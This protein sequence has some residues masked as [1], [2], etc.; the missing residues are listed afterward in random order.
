MKWPPVLLMIWLAAPVNAWAAALHGDTL[1]MSGTFY[2]LASEKRAETPCMLT[3]LQ[4]TTRISRLCT[5]PNGWRQA[6]DV[7]C[8]EATDKTQGGWLCSDAR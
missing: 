8:G 6:H 4:A 1:A 3:A 2:G 7:T 5:W